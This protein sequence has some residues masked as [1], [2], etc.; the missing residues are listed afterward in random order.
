MGQQEVQIKYNGKDVEGTDLEFET[1]KE[2]WNEYRL[3]DG[4]ILKMKVA[5]T[6]VVRLDGETDAATGNPVYFIRS[7]NLTNVVVPSKG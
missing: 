2:A 4:T 5:V 6:G 3:D 7:S 1:V